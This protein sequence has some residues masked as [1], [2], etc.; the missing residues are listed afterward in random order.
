AL[1]YALP[2]A[3]KS[4][5]PLGKEKK[6][7]AT[8]FTPR[9]PSISASRVINIP[10]CPPRTTSCVYFTRDILADCAGASAGN[11]NTDSKQANAATESLSFLMTRFSKLSSLMTPTTLLCFANGGFLY[12]AHFIL[13]PYRPSPSGLS[14]LVARP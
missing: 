5:L 3:A 11:T 2:G 4:A 13:H 6:A 14:H 1:L 7:A 10:L 12:Q 8:T 9:S